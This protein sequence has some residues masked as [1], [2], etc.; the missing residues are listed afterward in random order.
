MERTAS[1][2]AD[3]ESDNTQGIGY[4]FKKCCGTGPNGESNWWKIYIRPLFLKGENPDISALGFFK[5]NNTDINNIT[6]NSVMG[7]VGTVKKPLITIYGAGDPCNRNLQSGNN[8]QQ[9]YLVTYGVTTN[10]T[11][12]NINPNIYNG[13]NL[14]N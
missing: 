12:F 10:K 8:T 7:L 13:T 3:A 4:V 6:I 14:Y 2:P 11:R 9:N 1:N 5:K